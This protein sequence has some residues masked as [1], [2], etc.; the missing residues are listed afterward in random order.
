MTEINLLPNLDFSFI[1][2]I[3]ELFVTSIFIFFSLLTLRQ[4]SIMNK[5]VIT[6]LAPEL[7]IAAL[8]Q[9]SASVLVF[10]LIFLV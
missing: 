10:L 5:S 1:L 2:K 9:L 6:N 3:F 7:K 4:V 8:L